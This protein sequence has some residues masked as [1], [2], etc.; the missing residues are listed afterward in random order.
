MQ[1]TPGASQKETPSAT[2]VHLEPASR[3]HAPAPTVI[4]DT[5][6]CILLRRAAW[7]SE[8]LIGLDRRQM[9]SRRSFLRVH[10]LERIRC[11]FI[12][13]VRRIRGKQL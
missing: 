5:D 13:V 10:G 3:A 6:R 8:T 11:H 2:A 1:V 7:G 9:L 12:L 4:E